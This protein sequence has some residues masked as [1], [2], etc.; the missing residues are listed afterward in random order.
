MEFMDYLASGFGFRVPPPEAP[1]QRNV[2]TD[3]AGS[4]VV[5][6]R[7]RQVRVTSR[8]FDSVW[9][10]TS[11][12]LPSGFWKATFAG[13]RE[14]AFDAIRTAPARGRA[15]VVGDGGGLGHRGPF[16]RASFGVFP[17]S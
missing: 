9:A 10:A 8:G 5:R 3:R 1:S 11:T 7:P 6:T 13:A 16:D 17:G 4:S 15:A 14:P 2:A 12:T